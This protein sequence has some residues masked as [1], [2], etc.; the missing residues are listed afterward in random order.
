MTGG[1]ELQELVMS[2]RRTH[3]WIITAVL[4]QFF[5]ALVVCAN[6]SH[7]VLDA[8]LAVHGKDPCAGW[9][10]EASSVYETARKNLMNFLEKEQ[11]NGLKSIDAEDLGKTHVMVTMI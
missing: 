8:P 2:D 6:P 7:K 3:P 1:Y 4:V 9:H 10:K 11:N 5:A